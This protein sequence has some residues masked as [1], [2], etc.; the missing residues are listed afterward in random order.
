MLDGETQ[1]PDKCED[2]EIKL[3]TQVLQSGS[4][5]YL[6]TQCNC[7]PYSRESDYFV[8]QESAEAEL[9]L[10]VEESVKPHSRTPGYW[11]D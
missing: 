1:S 8:T 6:G 7:G 2:C 11:G 4:G 10:W 5:Y 9:K 3:D